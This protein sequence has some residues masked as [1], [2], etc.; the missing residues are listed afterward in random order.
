MAKRTR[1]QKKVIDP[2]LKQALEQAPADS[3]VQATFTLT[4]PAGE[5]YRDKA[6]TQAAVKDLIDKASTAAAPP[7][8]VSVFPN[9]QSFAVAGSPA[10]VREIIKHE[11][12]ASAMSNVQKKEI[13][14]RPAEKPKP[15]RRTP[16]AK[17]K[18]KR[19]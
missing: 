19:R 1:P 9:V 17:K 16:P 13:F 2:E 5:P 11:D 15:K 7:N 10:F 12:V 6:S 3:T 8:R 14:I 4:T 18:K